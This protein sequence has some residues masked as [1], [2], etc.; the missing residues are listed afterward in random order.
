MGN[1]LRICHDSTVSCHESM[2]YST[3]ARRMLIHA[4]TRQSS[5]PTAKCRAAR[6]GPI[7]RSLH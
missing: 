2:V 7:R 3:A 1:D 4:I 5:N 6:G